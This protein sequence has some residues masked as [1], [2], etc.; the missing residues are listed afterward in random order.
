MTTPPR[1]EAV[2]LFN[3][4]SGLQVRRLVQRGRDPET[5]RLTLEMSDGTI[6]KVGTFEKLLSRAQFDRV[7]AATVGQLTSPCTPAEWKGAVARLVRY[8]TDVTETPDETLAS[9]VDDWLD[10]YA[11]EAR[12]DRD[13]AAKRREPFL[14]ETLH[15]HAEHFTRW[16]KR[17]YSEQIPAI[18]VRGA[19]ADLGYEPVRIQWTTTTGRG[20]TKTRKQARYMRAPTAAEDAP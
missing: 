18:D 13:G 12:S 16:L 19:L 20:K 2:E 17:E 14:D 11:A 9:R 15:V 1:A 10:Q 8:A 3:I 7:V 6:V 4:V 5:A